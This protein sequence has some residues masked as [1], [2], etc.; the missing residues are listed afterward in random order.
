MLVQERYSNNVLFAK[1]PSSIPVRRKSKVHVFASYDVKV[2]AGCRSCCI[3]SVEFD[4][5]VLAD[6]T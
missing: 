1:R 3:F 6:L 5:E 4:V 2:T